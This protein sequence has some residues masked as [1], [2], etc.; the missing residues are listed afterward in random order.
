ALLEKYGVNHECHS[1]EAFIAHL[2]HEKGVNMFSS[3]NGMFAILIWD[4]QERKLYG[5]RDHFG[6]QPLYYQENDI[7][8]IVASEKKSITK[9]YDRDILHEEALQHYLSFQYVP[10][11]FTLSEG[12]KKL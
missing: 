10:E 6:I 3:L 9:L 8:I 4:H 1:T 12:I 5:V 11:P 2:F 7:E